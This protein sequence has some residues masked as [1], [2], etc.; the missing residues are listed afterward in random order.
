MRKRR[1]EITEGS[2]DENR[3]HQY[4]KQLNAAYL[5]KRLIVFYGA[6][7]SMQLNLPGWKE[8]IQHVVEE[9]IAN[10][11]QRKACIEEI[12]RVNFWEAMEHVKSVAKVGEDKIRSL[13]ANSAA[14]A[15]SRRMSKASLR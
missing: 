9:V 2:E 10:P 13:I 5:K 14:R 15:A 7:L 11:Q 12:D 3:L 8:L 1:E 4:I 6:G